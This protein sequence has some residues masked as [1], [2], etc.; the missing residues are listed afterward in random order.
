MQA[1]PIALMAAGSMV[2]GIGGYKAGKYNA[3]VAEEN[4]V[5][6]DNEGAAEGARISDEARAA[7][8]EQA[9]SLSGN[10]FEGGTGSALTRL[11]E[12]SIAAEMDIQ[13]ARRRARSRAMAY[14]AEGKAA[15]AAGRSALIGGL[16]G[17]ASAVSHVADYAQQGARYGYGGGS[18]G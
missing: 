4:A 11:R 18:G 2:Q 8:G 6:A 15:K 5:N 9:A 17:A 1:I 10:G 12:S 3:K 16:F 13:E 14:R 7:T